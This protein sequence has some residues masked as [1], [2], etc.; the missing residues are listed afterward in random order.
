MLDP[1]ALAAEVVRITTAAPDESAWLQHARKLAKAAPSKLSGRQLLVDVSAVARVDLK[2][3]IQRVVKAQ[4]LA[5]LKCP[6]T[7]FRVEPV[8]LCNSDSQWRYRYARNYMAKLLSLPESILEDDPVEVAEGDIFYAPDYFT[9]GVI[10]ASASGI[11]ADWSAQGVEINFLVHDILPLTMPKYFPVYSE[12][13]HENWLRA[14]AES[15]D[16]LICVSRTVAQET[17]GW[18][19]LHEPEVLPHLEIAVSHHGADI[20][21]FDPSKGLPPDAGP[22]LHRLSSCPSFLMVG[23]IE[24]RKGHLQVLTAFE[25]LWAQGIDINLVIAGAEGWKSVAP[26]LRRNISQIVEKLRSHPKLGTRLFWLEDISDEFLDKVYTAS[27]CLIAASQNE[28]FGLPLIE[29][30]QHG[31]P[32][33]ARDTSVFREVAGQYAGYFSGDDAESLA[34][35]VKDWLGLYLENRHSKSDDMPWLTWEQSTDRLKLILLG[36]DI[37]ALR[38]SSRRIR[39]K[40]R[41]Q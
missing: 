13:M 36:E 18:L 20:N 21:A 23:T 24:P 31:V 15:S 4:L 39:A 1:K 10:E 37:F 2:T 3:G 12:K 27:A 6:P 5:L 19:K 25:R 38:D 14:I 28:G 16:R 11:Y 35:T 22:V 40:L 34:N 30:A 26:E 29:A 7:G 32:I 33:L 17:H 8:R 41:A 9:D